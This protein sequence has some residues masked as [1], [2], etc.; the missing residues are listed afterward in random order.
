MF[1]LGVEPKYKSAKNAIASLYQIPT[2]VKND[3][4]S[5][6]RQGE[7]FFTTFTE[8][9]YQKLKSLKEITEYSKISGDE[10]FAKMTYEF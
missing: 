9:G 6:S 10:Y 5:I 2:I 1:F 8:E 7:R 3:I 4:K